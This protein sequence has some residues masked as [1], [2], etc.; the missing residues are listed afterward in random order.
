[1]KLNDSPPSMTP[2]ASQTFPQKPSRI[3]SNKKPSRIVSN[4]GPKQATEP[5]L[6]ASRK[7]ASDRDRDPTPS[8][9]TSHKS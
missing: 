4:T 9:A 6:N 5:K 8:A 7:D 1:M 3:I 2:S